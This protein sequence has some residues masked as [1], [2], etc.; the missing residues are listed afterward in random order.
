M[1]NNTAQ[2]NNPH[3]NGG[4]DKPQEAPKPPEFEQETPHDPSK[5]EKAV[6]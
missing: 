1:A 3:Q 5:P 4:D 6:Q 2:T